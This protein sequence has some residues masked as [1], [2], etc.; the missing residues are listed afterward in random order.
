M[1]DPGASATAMGVVV[2]VEG[3]LPVDTI[4]VGVLIGAVGTVQAEQATIKKS[5]KRDVGIMSLSIRYVSDHL[6]APGTADEAALLVG[7]AIRQRSGQL[8]DR[9][10]K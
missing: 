1:V 8:L 7:I 4:E 5:D 10:D 2:G 9:S 3:G 6:R